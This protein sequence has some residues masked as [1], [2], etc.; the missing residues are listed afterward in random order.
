MVHHYCPMLRFLEYA[1]V[2][3]RGRSHTATTA[4][5]VRLVVALAKAGGTLRCV[6]VSP[7]V[8]M[9]HWPCRA[10]YSL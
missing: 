10:A 5:R 8:S 9:S 4:E 3:R 7:M 6:A 2:L 1:S